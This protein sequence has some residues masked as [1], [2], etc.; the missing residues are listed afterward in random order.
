MNKILL[1]ANGK[2]LVSKDGKVLTAPTSSGGSGGNYETLLEKIELN[3]IIWEDDNIN[4]SI[5]EPN[6]NIVKPFKL[7][8]FDDKLHIYFTPMYCP[9]NESL[10][11]QVCVYDNVNKT[12]K[13]G[14]IWGSTA[15]IFG[16]YSI[17]KEYFD[18]T[19]DGYTLKN[20]G[21]NS[22][23]VCYLITESNTSLVD[24]NFI[25]EM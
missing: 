5:E 20:Y 16:A 19:I 9:N 23:G 13:E 2:A 21:I 22:D 15:N 25:Y 17:Q 11:V 10:D 24:P 3:K 6:I 8:L 7:E 4:L 14:C 18:V 1:D 12:I